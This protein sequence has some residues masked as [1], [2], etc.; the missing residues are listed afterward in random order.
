[1]K[2]FNYQNRHIDYCSLLRMASKGLHLL[3]LQQYYILK[4]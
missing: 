2:G 3:G 4:I 1:M